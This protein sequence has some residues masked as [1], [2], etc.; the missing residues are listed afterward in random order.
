MREGDAFP[1]DAKRWIEALTWHETL[2]E[3]DQSRLTSTLIRDWQTWHAD[4][5]NQRIFDHMSR[6]ATDARRKGRRSRPREVEIAEDRYDPAVSI[7]LWNRVRS[8][9]SA[10]HRLWCANRLSWLT[11]AVAL[12]AAA[13]IVALR[14]CSPWDGAP[15]RRGGGFTTFQ[16]GT[17]ELKSVHLRDGSDVTLGGRTKILVAFSTQ[18]RSVELIRGEAWFRVAHDPRWP[19][20]VH[21]GDGAITAVGTAFLVTRDADRV[22]VTVTEGTISVSSLPPMGRTP[23]RSQDTGSLRRPPTVR[24][25]RGE[26]ISYRDNGV[27][28]PIVIADTDAATAWTHGRLVFND[29]PLRYVIEDVNRYF[30]R[31]ITVSA[32]AGGLRFSGVVLRGEIEEW[33]RRLP[34]IVPV[35]VDEHGSGICVRMHSDPLNRSCAAAR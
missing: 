3:A 31:R 33:L 16:T 8:T 30:P 1:E 12:A 26:E 5:E 2:T 32:S 9:K 27:M 18:A 25:T 34:E 28:A 24:V 13:A 23:D 14:F 6:L 19:F 10:D 29:E 4:P 35:D 20:V 17:G 22:V 7:A 11:A 15:I 21:A